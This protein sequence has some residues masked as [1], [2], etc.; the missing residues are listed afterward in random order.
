MLGSSD[1]KSVQRLQSLLTS[2]AAQPISTTHV[3]GALLLTAT[4]RSSKD[5][6]IST[7]YSVFLPVHII[8]DEMRGTTRVARQNGTLREAQ[9]DAR[10]RSNMCLRMGTTCNKII[11]T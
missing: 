5:V 10:S 3:H 4:C 11:S 8:S 9:L 7:A 6:W 2:H 1:W